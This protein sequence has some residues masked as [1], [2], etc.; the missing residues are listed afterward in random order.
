MTPSEPGLVASP[1]PRNDSIWV[2][3]GGELLPRAQAKVSVFDSVVQNGD[4][5]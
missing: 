3:V 5:E 1:D 4:A 2:H